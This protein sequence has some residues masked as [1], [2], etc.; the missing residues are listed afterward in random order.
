MAPR[1]S[2]LWMARPLAVTALVAGA[3]G[4]AKL[5]DRGL[6]SGWPA[7]ARF[8]FA[9][10]ILLANVGAVAILHGILSPAHSGLSPRVDSDDRGPT[11]RRGLLVGAAVVVA[12]VALS[13]VLESYLGVSVK[14]TLLVGFGAALAWATAQKPWWFWDHWKA[15]ILRDLI[16]DS[17]TTAVYLLI[18]AVLLYLAIL[19]DPSR[20]IR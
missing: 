14:R 5:V 9:S 1:R 10:A 7:W 8:A 4:A 18:A 15:H 2:K 17:A 12:Y 3:F 19:G 13:K 6:T 16:G 11:L 20:L